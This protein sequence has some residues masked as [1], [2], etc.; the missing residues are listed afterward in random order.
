MIH[1]L[2]ALVVAHRW[3]VIL[4]T[5][6]LAAVGVRSYAALPID[7]VPDITN[8][9]VQVLTA[10]PGLSPLEVESMV[11]RPVEL[12]LACI[13]HTQEVR[14]A[15]RA[16]VSAVT[17]IFDDELPIEDARALVAQR[18]PAARSRVLGSGAPELGP[19]SSGL[20]EIL[21]FT[22]AWPGHTPAEI[23]TLLDWEIAVIGG[24]FTATILTLGLLPA[25][26]ASGFLQ[27]LAARRREAPPGDVTAAAP[28]PGS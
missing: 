5:L 27:R 20:G 6:V 22:I 28:A 12:S 23:R 19:M 11:T 4:A 9:Q 14:S 8:V 13:P 15:S 1:R 2:V 3:I 16:G 24:L 17:V 7:A 10:A 21:H 25:I 18:L 26:H